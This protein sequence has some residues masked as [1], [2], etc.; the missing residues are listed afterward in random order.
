MLAT[1]LKDVAALGVHPALLATRADG[2]LALQHSQHDG[3]GAPPLALRERCA[4]EPP[5]DAA[6]ARL[7][8]TNRRPR[9]RILSSPPAGTETGRVQLPPQ[10]REVAAALVG[11]RQ[12]RVPH[13]GAVG[14]PRRDPRPV[15]RPEEP[16]RVLDPVRRAP[17]EAMHHSQRGDAPR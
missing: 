8:C 9:T 2:V 7:G 5:Q 1:R 3:S 13:G 4:D 10:K 17:A 6:P 11:F 15:I 12:R 14:I 16:K